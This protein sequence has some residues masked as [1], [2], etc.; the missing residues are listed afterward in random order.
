MQDVLFKKSRAR[1]LVPELLCKNSV[2]YDPSYEGSRQ[3]L[4]SPIWRPLWC[5]KLVVFYAFFGV[6]EKVQAESESPY[7]EASWSQIPVVFHGFL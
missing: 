6:L 5:Q 1:D 7:L 3:G 2:T 4:G